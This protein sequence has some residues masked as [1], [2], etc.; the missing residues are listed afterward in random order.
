MPCATLSA[1][2]NSVRRFF[3][4]YLCWTIILRSKISSKCKFC[5][6]AAV[7]GTSTSTEEKHTKKR[8]KMGLKERNGPCLLILCSPNTH[9]VSGHISST[10]HVYKRHFQGLFLLYLVK[11]FQRIVEQ[12]LS[13]NFTRCSQYFE[14]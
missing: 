13:S 3:Q 12:P 10:C 11:G 2:F 5:K 7:P 14:S 8:K 1:H 6:E 9:L 4:Q